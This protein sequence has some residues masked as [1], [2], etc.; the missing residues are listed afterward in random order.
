MTDEPHEPDVM[1]VLRAARDPLEGPG[2]LGRD[3]AYRTKLLLKFALR[4]LGFRCVA[5]R[6]VPAGTKP[7]DVKADELPGEA[8]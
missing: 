6:D 1:I 5:C 4:S 8:S 7:A 3:A 2:I